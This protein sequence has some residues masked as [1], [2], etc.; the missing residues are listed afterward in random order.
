MKY[1]QDILAAIARDAQNQNLDGNCD[2]TDSYN[3]GKDIGMVSRLASLSRAF[4]TNHYQTL[5]ES[6]RKCLEKWLRVTG[7]LE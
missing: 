1:L 7:T 3:G 5:D 4:G 6:I 2:H